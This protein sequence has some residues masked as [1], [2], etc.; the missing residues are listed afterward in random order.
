VD[1]VENLAM[2]RAR[3]LFHAEY[4][5][6]Q[7]HSGSQANMAVYFAILQPG[8]LLMGMD[9]RQGGHLTHGS[10]ASFTGRLYRVVSYGVRRDTEY[11]LR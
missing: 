10:P 4:A 2:E 11:R 9:L 5:N 7:P 8:D 3:Q 1:R 6:V